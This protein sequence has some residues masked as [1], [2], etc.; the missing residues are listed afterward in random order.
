MAVAFFTRR[1][2]GLD[3]CSVTGMEDRDINIFIGS[4]YFPFKFYDLIGTRLSRSSVENIGTLGS[5][6]CSEQIV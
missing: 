4:E 5:A 1:S 6:N 2:G 3:I